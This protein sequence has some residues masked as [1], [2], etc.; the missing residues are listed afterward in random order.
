M[1]K[2]KLSAIALF[3]ACLGYAQST[4]SGKVVSEKGEILL[5]AN[6]QL[7]ELNK[8]T[9]TDIDGNFVFFEVEPGVYT[10]K[11]QYVGFF[12]VSKELIV[13]GDLNTA[14]VM[15]ENAMLDQEV[16]VNATRANAK[17]P[18]T[19]TNVSNREIEERNLGQDLPILLKMTPSVVT[20]SDAGAGVGYTGMRIR[21]SDATRINVTMNGVPVNDS[22]SHG[23]FWVNMPDLAS[24]TS[25]IQIQRGVGT[26]SNGAASFGASVNLQ[27]D[28]FSQD[29]SA[30]LSTSVGSFNT[31]KISAALESGILSDHWSFQT[32]FSKINSDG[33]IDRSAADLWSYYVSG[34][35][36]SD[37]TL[38][39]AIVF[40]GREETQQAWYGTPEA[41]L[42]GNKEAL[43]EVVDLGGEY[44][45]QAQ[46][47]N[48]FN[49]DRR[50]NYYLYDNEVDNYAQDH[51]QLHLSQTLTDNLYFAGALHYTYGRGYFE[52]FREDD[53]FANYNLNN[54]IEEGTEISSGDFIRR[55][56]LDNDFYGFTY[57]LNYEQNGF[58]AV[59]GGG[60][61]KYQG[62]H[63]GEIIDSEYFRIADIPER[64]YDGIGEKTDFNA[65]LKV[66]YQVGKINL[67]GDAQIRRINYETV[68]VDNDLTGY[69]TG[70]DY[71]FFN[72]KLGFTYEVYKNAFIYASYA[73]AN[74]EPVRSD[75]IDA[76]EGVTPEH[77]T[78]HNVEA[79]I[80]KSGTKFSYNLNYYLMKYNNQ[81]VLTGALNDVGSSI[82][83]NVPNSYRA[84]IEMVATYKLTKAIT[85]S[86]NA[87][88][89]QNKI[90][91][92]NEIYYDYAYDDDRFVSETS[93]QETDISFSPNVIVGSDIKYSS[94][95]FTAQLFSKYVGKQYLDNTS[96]ENR[97]ISSYFIND[98]RLAYTLPFVK[99]LDIDIN[100]LV[101][102]I[103]NVTYEN[104]GYTWG[105]LF[106]GSLYQQNNY[107]PQAGINFL[108]GLNIRL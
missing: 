40:G 23:V 63:F 11:A 50:F 53:D 78:L 72:P 38:I 21:G 17:S 105:Y 85:W 9:T 30:S 77:E 65:Y 68:G 43:Q 55:R 82:R 41:R 16:I 97:T 70:G 94:K 106:E 26:S 108:A 83:T 56:W 14:I 22:E 52:Q 98:V 2:F 35:Y 51:F 49:S 31:T 45:T 104:N 39:K 27:T 96:N 47:D 37:K 79:G 73:V 3:L 10:I 25:D 58:S 89:S 66:N 87:T 7:I 91:N 54:L 19:F 60:W 44:A 24:S 74:R 4:I 29:A 18:T 81:L 88:F 76:P 36:R 93:Y 42:T 103:L 64:Y 107:Y 12:D 75:F 48:L 6:V 34:G 33:Y 5:G 92:F 67:Y 57:S 102:N 20:T 8:I 1:L 32:R 59:L 62:D 100:L 28:G 71:T 90:E 84:G 69:D 15:K 101:N 95:G 99:S 13:D 86:A 46:V 61:N 80:R